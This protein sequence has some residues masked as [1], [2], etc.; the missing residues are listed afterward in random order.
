MGNEFVIAP[1][2]DDLLDA[3]GAI[4]RQRTQNR[5]IDDK[6]DPVEGVELVKWTDVSPGFVDEIVEILLKK[7]L[8]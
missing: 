2:I 1:E 5:E 8:G 4:D 7:S 6:N 3:V